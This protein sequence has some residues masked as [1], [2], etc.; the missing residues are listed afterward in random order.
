[1]SKGVKNNLSFQFSFS[2]LHD[3]NLAIAFADRI[4]FMKQ[5]KIIYETK[6]LSELSTEIIMDVFDVS[7]TI[8]YPAH[9]K[10]VVIF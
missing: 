7:S 10:P 1:M 6:Q 4:L 9:H 2:F 8:L 3:V 5:G